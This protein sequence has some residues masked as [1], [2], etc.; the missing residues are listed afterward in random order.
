[1]SHRGIKSRQN[2]EDSRTADE[3]KDRRCEF[4]DEA[5]LQKLNE[6]A[7]GRLRRRQARSGGL[8]ILHE[9]DGLDHTW[10]LNCSIRRRKRGSPRTQTE[11][12][13]QSMCVVIEVLVAVV[14]L[15]TPSSLRVKSTET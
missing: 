8:R 1:V 12:L 5:G 7:C 14:V 13:G 15:H 6:G 9:K 4:Q 10:L 11:Q 3:K 2:V